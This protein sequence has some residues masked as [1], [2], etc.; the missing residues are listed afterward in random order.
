MAGVRAGL[1]EGV[2]LKVEE[3][4]LV[5]GEDLDAAG[6]TAILDPDDVGAFDNAEEGGN[7]GMVPV[8]GLLVGLLDYVIDALGG[9]EQGLVELDGSDLRAAGDGIREDT[10]LSAHGGRSQG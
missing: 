1:D 9:G 5:A 4:N 8:G 3:E 7:D 2:G 10:E 6:K